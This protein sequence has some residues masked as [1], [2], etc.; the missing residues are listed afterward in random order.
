[1]GENGVECS[2]IV[3]NA[4]QRNKAITR[5]KIG[6]DN[7]VL[8]LSLN[9]SASGTN[10]TE[11]THIFFVEPVDETKE[12]IM[13]IESQAIARAVRLGQKQQVEIVRILCKDT[14]EEEIY[15]G[16]YNS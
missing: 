6:T 2:F 14:I 7:N 3:G 15:N 9:K 8:L 13:A 4:Y 11:A 5:F 1:M 12:N 16:K 10:L